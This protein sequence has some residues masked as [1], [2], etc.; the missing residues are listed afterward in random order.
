M[1]FITRHVL[2]TKSSSRSNLLN[3]ARVA[4]E[5]KA[6]DGPD[7]VDAAPLASVKSVVRRNTVL[8]V[9]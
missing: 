9:L 6:A 5:V 1:Q 3:G 2:V 8:N 7:H 4:V